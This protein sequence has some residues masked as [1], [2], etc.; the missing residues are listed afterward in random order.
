MLLDSALSLVPWQAHVALAALGLVLWVVI[1]VA[2]EEKIIRKYGEHA[3]KV[4]PRGFI[5]FDSFL[6]FGFVWDFFRYGR[7]DEYLKFTYRSIIRNA[8]GRTNPYTFELRI[9]GLRYLWTSDPDN[10]KAML[11]S[12]FEDYG[13]GAPFR[14]RWRHVL[15]TSI[16]NVDGK[17]WH[18]SRHRLRPLFSRQRISEL[19]AIEKHIQRLMSLHLDGGRTI[20]FKDVISRFAL[21]T[22]G[23]YAM[24][25]QVNA[26]AD[27]KNDF[28]DAL[29]AI[30]TM[31]SI[32]EC[33]GPLSPLLPK[34]GFKRN[35]K[36]LDDFIG[37]F[38]DKALATPQAVLDEMEKTDKD[39][40]FMK[41][42]AAVSRD[43]DFLKFEL[44]S[45]IFA[46]RDSVPGTLTWTF[47]ELAKRPDLVADLRR[48][49]NGVV[50]LGADAPSPTHADLKSMRLINNTL[51]ETLRL[52]PTVSLNLRTAL[53]DT[54]LPRGGGHDGNAQVGLAEGTTVIFSSHMLHMMPETYDNAP[55]GSSPPHVYDPYRWD[56]WTPKPWTYIPFGG[57]PR[58]CLGQQLALTEMAFVVVRLL[59]RYSRLEL[60]GKMRGIVEQY[61]TEEGRVRISGDVTLQP[62]DKVMMRFLP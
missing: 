46:G 33:A 26:L 57:G 50:G 40:T 19:G 53:K 17:A 35:L 25:C 37:P 41:A 9:G 31:Q 47:I 45:I 36:V 32:H 13:R 29:E 55:A 15:G 20:D 11:A 61:L 58:L 14:H 43:R 60:R 16:F 23:E 49:I 28:L 62:R 56:N 34:P 5:P 44:M 24:G 48:E 7:R 39:W 10:I 22:I 51:N 6:G 18:D 38:I 8:A 54:S 3:T 4:T 52:Y 12:Q 21:D 2:R 30:K 27:R 59:Q 1:A 42:C